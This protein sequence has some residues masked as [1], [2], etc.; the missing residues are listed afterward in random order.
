M[1][2]PQSSHHFIIYIYKGQDSDQEE[3]H[4]SSS[5]EEEEYTRLPPITR[6]RDANAK[7]KNDRFTSQVTR[8]N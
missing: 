1:H 6:E 3:D 8:F 4:D 7:Q 5:E 2:D